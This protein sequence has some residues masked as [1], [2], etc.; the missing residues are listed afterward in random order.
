MLPPEHF[1]MC[2]MCIVLE[3]GEYMLKSLTLSSEQA[4]THPEPAGD[5]LQLFSSVYE[6]D[7]S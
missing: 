1:V 7:G 2:F 3:S 5:I 4:W 6:G